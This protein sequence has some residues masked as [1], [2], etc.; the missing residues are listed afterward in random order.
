MESRLVIGCK[1]C[2]KKVK[3]KRGYTINSEGL[4]RTPITV[5]TA[6]TIHELYELFFEHYNCPYCDNKLHIEPEI[7]LFANDFIDKH[8]HIIFEPEHIEIIN[9]EE[10]II[11]KDEE[12]EVSESITNKLNNKD[13]K[14]YPSL[15]EIQTIYQAKRKVDLKKWYFYIESGT[16]KDPYFIKYQRN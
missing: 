11:F 15:D 4:L 2:F 5:H 9:D 1:S 7:M 3:K 10:T 14:N 8:Y 13:T 6:Y 16:T 12:I